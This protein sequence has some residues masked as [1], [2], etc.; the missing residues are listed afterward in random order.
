LELFWNGTLT[1]LAIGFWASLAN[2]SE[3]ISPRAA[4]AK[5][6]QSK[7]PA[8]DTH[9]RTFMEHCPLRMERRMF[10]LLNATVSIK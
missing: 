3:D 7:L 6:E 2:S 4:V 1:R 9:R 8:S 10:V 5:V